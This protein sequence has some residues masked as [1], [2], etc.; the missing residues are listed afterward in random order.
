MNYPSV[1]LNVAARN[2]GFGYHK[3]CQKTRLTKLCFTDDFLIFTDGGLV[4]VQGV[5]K[6]L[7][8]FKELSSLAISINKNSF[9]TVGLSDQEVS[10]I[11]ASIGLSQGGLLVRYLGVPLCTKKLLIICEPL[12]HQI[13]DKK[14][15]HGVLIAFYLLGVYS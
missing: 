4:S 10:T 8:S 6:V 14:Y 7:H 1:M 15:V 2:H 9:Y 5:L 11:F 12:L 13:K 3:H